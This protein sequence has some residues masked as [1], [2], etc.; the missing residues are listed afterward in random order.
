MKLYFSDTLN[1]RKAC[2]VAKYLGLPIEFV[3]VALEKGE[4]R[5]P[6]FRAMNPNAK[7]PVLVDGDTT[8][9]ESNAIMCYLAAKAGSDLWP[10][11][12]RQIEV[13]RW[14]MWDATE[15]APQAGTL[16]FEHIV[17]PRFGIG[18]PDAAEVQ[19]ATQGFLRYAA[20]L[21]AHLRGRRYLVGEALSV[22]DFAAAI[23]LPYAE[24]AKLPL[25]DFPEIRRWHEQ[26]NK[27]E[28]WREPFTATSAARA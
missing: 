26:L 19:K 6:A 25:A 2:A 5:T 27:L 18:P 22:A 24:E 4:H 3:F 10:R 8:L 20:V 12:K 9:W 23:T 21:E 11:D 17:K 15:F 1:P 16:Y 13:M 14:L 28:A 7:V